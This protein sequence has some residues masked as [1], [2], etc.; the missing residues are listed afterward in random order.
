MDMFKQLIWAYLKHK[1]IDAL[2]HVLNEAD[3]VDVLHVIQEL[4]ADEQAIV[5]RLLSKDK[6]LFIFEQLETSS[7]QALIRSFTDEKAIEMIKELAP[8]DR[9]SLLDELPA[10]VAKRMLAAL[11]PEEREI[12]N[13]LMGY[14]TET[15]GRI[16]TPAYV[17]LKRDMTVADALEKVKFV[18]RETDSAKDKETIYSLYITDDARK[19]EGVLSLRDLLIADVCAH[20]ETIMQK[21][22]AKVSTDTDQEEVARLL[23]RL[24][25]LAVP[26]VDKEERLVGIITVD[27][28]IDVITQEATEDMSKMAGISPSEKPYTNTTTF[29]IFKARIPWLILLMLVAIA[30]AGIIEY[31]EHAISVH[32]ILAASIPMLMDTAGNSGSQSSVTIV[33]AMSLGEVRFADIFKIVWKESRIAMIC[34]V[35]LAIVNF[36]RMTLFSHADVM[37]ALVVS[38]TLVITVFIAKTLGAALPIVAKSIKLDPAVMSS[39]VVTSIADILALLVYF[40]IAT[41]LLGI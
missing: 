41:M 40:Q 15:A 18:A 26:V 1:D 13:L 3:E 34:G 22:I 38:L 5:Y 27:D 28:I 39:T 10:A 12:T 6:A 35:V 36:L 11:S 37:V 33:R 29:E 30:T 2:K 19:L 25:L 9:V 7:Q 14:E 16:M 17:R 31:Y 32:T 20:V 24:D 4:P 23:Q 8:D 21:S